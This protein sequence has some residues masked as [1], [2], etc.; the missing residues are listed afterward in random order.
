MELVVEIERITEKFPSQERYGLVSQMNK[1]AI[2]ITKNI[3]GGS[4][5]NTKKDFDHFWRFL[6][7]LPSN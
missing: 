3:V 2:S 7:V 5:R 6:L 1:C 4:V